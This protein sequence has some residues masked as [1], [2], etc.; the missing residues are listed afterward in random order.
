[1]NIGLFT[2]T[3]TPQINGVVS[4]IHTLSDELTA[5]GHT[6]YIFAP[7]DPLEPADETN[8][9]RMPSMPIIFVRQ[10]RWGMSYSPKALANIARLHLDIIHTQTEFSLGFFG[11]LLAKMKHTP[12][13]HTYHTMLEDYV[14]YIVNGALIKP[15]MAK[16]YSKLFC[17][18]TN[19]VIA[20]TVKTRNTLLGYHV[21]KPIEVIPTGIPLRQF[22]KSNF[23]PRET[24][25][26]KSQLGLS[27]TAPIILS[28]GRVA[29]E[30]SIDVIL[31][32]LPQVLQQ[33]PDAMFVIVGDGPAQNSLAALAQELQIADRVLF[34][35]AKPWEEIGRYYQLGDVFV[36][37]SITET[38]G[39]T[40]A[41]A[42]AAGVPVI[43]KRDESIVGLVE[44][45]E[46]GFLFSTEEEL[47]QKLLFVLSQPE[48]KEKIAVTAAARVENLSSE[49]FAKHVEALYLEVL[50]KP[51]KYSFSTHPL[52][53]KL[54]KLPGKAVIKKV[55]RIN[56]TI[57]KDVY[58]TT[59]T[60]LFIVRRPKKMVKHMYKRASRALDVKM[61][62]LVAHQQKKEKEK[63]S[64]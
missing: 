55:A 18:A 41:E 43:A 20:P 64:K 31:H 26:L 6:V 2:D 52:L 25:E 14:H 47:A 56:R 15:A 32:T 4:S 62:T 16:E 7:Y 27:P 8:V 36:S 46:T 60:L 10:F 63:D 45:E 37:A 48:Q 22:R 30:K 3:Y 59:R 12:T 53:P 23:D 13:I 35:G 61:K 5:L 38:Q 57:K 51:A 1:M 54:P 24:A 19:A 17:N 49:A 9:I 33:L 39:L 44:E 42:M 50:E 40:F 58:R 28:I 11:K 21:T 29:K 34:L